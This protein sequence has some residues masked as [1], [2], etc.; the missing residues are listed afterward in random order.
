M[1]SA[2]KPANVSLLWGAAQHSHLWEQSSN[3]QVNPSSHVCTVGYTQVHRKC[4]SSGRNQNQ[5][6]RTKNK[7]MKFEAFFFF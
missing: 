4:V 7:L 2:G 5:N 6:E 1:A 3:H